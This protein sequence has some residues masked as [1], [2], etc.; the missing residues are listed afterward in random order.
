MT[1][2]LLDVVRYDEELTDLGFNLVSNPD[3]WALVMAL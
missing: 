3:A 1:T 2:Y